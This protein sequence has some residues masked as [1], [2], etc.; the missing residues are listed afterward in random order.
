MSDF[1]DEFLNEDE[2]DE[3][4]ENGYVE[5]SC[6][7]IDMEEKSENVL[8]LISQEDIDDLERGDI[9]E[10]GI[11]IIFLAKNLTTN[12]DGIDVGKVV[13]GSIEGDRLFYRV[14][15]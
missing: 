2:I 15:Y 8:C 7:V 14:E 1:E 9:Y 4:Y 13:Y 6:T 5:T 11:K 10:E 3:Y 12:I